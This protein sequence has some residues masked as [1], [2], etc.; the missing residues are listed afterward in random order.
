MTR[1]IAQTPTEAYA[2]VNPDEALPSGDERYVALDRARGTRDVA[3]LLTELLRIRDDVLGAEASGNHVRFLVTGHSGCGKTTELYRL[4][5]ALGQAGFAV[6][7]FDAG[8]EFDLQKQ[9]VDPSTSAFLKTASTTPS[10][11]SRGWSPRK[12]NATT[13][14]AR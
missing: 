5:D 3:Q 10:S 13:W 2:T 14:K 7:Y 12:P 11:G 8:I 9:N 6:V 4:K 1:A